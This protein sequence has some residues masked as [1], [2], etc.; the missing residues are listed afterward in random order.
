MGWVANT[1]AVVFSF[2]VR[3]YCNSLGCLHLCWRGR[4]FILQHDIRLRM[5]ELALRMTSW[6]GS[7]GAMYIYCIHTV[8]SAE[9]LHS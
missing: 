7:Q 1:L 2:V 3:T 8:K 9:T 6:L 5:L 4:D